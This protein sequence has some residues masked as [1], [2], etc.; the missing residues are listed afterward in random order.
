MCAP[1]RDVQH[2][3]RGGTSATSGGACADARSTTCARRVLICTAA[4]ARWTSGRHRSMRRAYCMVVCSLCAAAEARLR[5][6]VARALPAAFY[7][8]AGSREARDEG[9]MQHRC[10]CGSAEL[11]LTKGAGL[12]A[13]CLRC[14]ATSRTQGLQAAVRKRWKALSL[15]TA[16]LA[17]VGRLGRMSAGPLAGLIDR[18]GV[19]Q[20]AGVC[21]RREHHAGSRD[22]GLR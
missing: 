9:R 17:R 13:S 22:R 19:R 1:R 18:C 5:L 4:A 2:L 14:A 10:F 8:G 7:L 16:P 12:R 15:R 6:Q 3:Q 21:W 11:R 20:S